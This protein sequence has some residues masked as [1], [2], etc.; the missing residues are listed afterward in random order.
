MPGLWEPKELG[1]PFVLYP[2]DSPKEPCFGPSLYRFDLQQIPV[3]LRNV[4]YRQL[5]LNDLF[6]Y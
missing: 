4:Y 1:Q 5:V 3:Y 2:D 6:T